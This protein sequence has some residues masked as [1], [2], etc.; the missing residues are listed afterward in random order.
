MCMCVCAKLLRSC[1]VLC[2]PVDSSPPG[3]PVH[4][5]LQAKVLEWVAMASSRGSSRPRDQTRIS[6]VSRV[7]RRALYHGCHL[8]SPLTDAAAAKS[9]QSCPTL[10]DL[11]KTS[12]CCARRRHPFLL[13]LKTRQMV[14]RDTSRRQGSPRSMG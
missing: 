4:G 6:Y 11:S 8:G 5:S 13:I 14:H 2:D 9:L 3:S 12:R 1:P 10:C 7:G